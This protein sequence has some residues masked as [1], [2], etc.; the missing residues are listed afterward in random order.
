[1]KLFIN[2]IFPFLSWFSNCEFEEIVFVLTNR[3]YV[4][5]AHLK[6]INDEMNG[7]VDAVIMNWAHFGIFDL[8][9]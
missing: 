5:L 9:S 1:M 6:V 7:F 4:L 8:E 3:L 2:A